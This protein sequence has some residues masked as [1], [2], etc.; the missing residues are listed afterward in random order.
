MQKSQT[1]T[2][3]NKTIQHMS[4]MTQGI[5]SGGILLS[6]DPGLG[7]AQPLTSNIKTPTGWTTMGDI[8]VGDYVSVPDGTSAPVSGVYPQGQKQ[9]YKITFSD[10]RTARACGE[11]LWETF[12]LRKH[13]WEILNTEQ[14]KKLIETTQRQV[15]IPLIAQSYTSDLEE[16]PMDPYVLGCLLGDG[17]MTSSS[18]TFS[19][20]DLEMIDLLSERL[21]NGY[22]LFKE[23]SSTCDYRLIIDKDNNGVT[24]PSR[25]RGEFYNSYRERLNDLGLLGSNSYT[26]F[27]PQLYK[28][29]S[30]Q[31]KEDLIAG[32]VDTDGHVT[33]KGGSVSISTSSHTMALDIQEIVWSMGGVCIIKERHPTYT[34]NGERKNG[35]VSYA[36]SIRYPTPRNL[37]KLTRKR[38]LLP[39]DT[40]QYKN[41]NLRIVK[42]EEDGI[43]EAQCIMVDHPDHL[44]ITDN[45]VVTHNTT[46]CELLGALLGIK[47]IIIEVPHITEE[48][49]INIPFLVY[50][51]VTNATQSGV[52]QES[53]YKM[54]LAQSNLYTQILNARPM[55]DAAYIQ[56]IK[57]SSKYIQDLYAQFGGTETEIPEII[58][59]AR[60]NFTVI[61]FLDEFFRRAP[62][63]VRNV[64]RD[65]LNKRIGMHKIPATTYILYASNMNDTGLDEMPSNYQFTQVDYK[66]PN[67]KDWFGW[68]ESKYHGSKEVQ[69]NEEV[70]AHFQEILTDEDISF[71]DVDSDVRTSPRRWEQLLLYIN[72]SLPVSD[73]RQA[74]ALLTNIH[75]NFVHYQ[76]KEM[77][78]NL[79]AK[80]LKAV[81]KLIKDTSDITVKHTDKLEESDWRD[82]L[83]HQITAQMKLGGHKKHIP[84]ISG[85][86]GVG[87]S[88]HAWDLAKKHNLR[89]IPV[90]ISSIYADDATGLPIPGKSDANKENMSIQ[91]S[92]PKL[93]HQIMEQIKAEDALYISKLKTEHGKKA[94]QYIDQYE[95]A[96]WKYL[97]MFDEINRVDEKTFNALRKV[98]LEKNFGP[99]GDNTGEDLR[100]PKEAI[101]IAALN[102][103]GVGTADLTSH[104][105]DVV[106]FVHAKASWTATLKVL[107]SLEVKDLRGKAISST[108]KEAGLNIIQMFVGKFKTKSS[109]TP[110]NEQPYHLDIGIPVYVSSREY[111]D[112]M[113]GLVQS[114]HHTIS[115][116]PQDA[117][118]AD[119]R[120]DINDTVAD[121]FDEN[122]SFPLTKAG[123][124]NTEFLSQVR[125]WVSSLPASAFVGLLAKTAKVRTIVDTMGDYLDGKNLDGM[126]DD[127][128]LVNA[129]NASNNSQVI[130]EVRE[131]FTSKVTDS[132]KVKHYIIDQNQ[133][134][135]TVKD[136]SLV[137]AGEP[138]SLLTNFVTSLIYTLHMHNYSNDRLAVIG[139]AVSV[140]FVEILKKMEEDD[141]IDAEVF[142]SARQAIS[143]LR[144]NLIDVVGTFK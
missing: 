39:D 65:I 134:S 67:K 93:Y 124:D 117:K 135:V 113:V 140:S 132:S 17:G 31:Q 15:H 91:F 74:H 75:N 137:Y 25:T 56:H 62:M 61:L 69:L 12:V 128:S 136:D 114:L 118:P 81:A 32:L 133:K 53:D 18:L 50:N 66:A 77:S 30:L 44:Y 105:R 70:I 3:I 90:D 72:A 58:K 38:D 43:E 94:E 22:K 52:S 10:G 28:T 127:V 14:I 82:T 108:F 130:D 112:L 84:I 64:L 129:H 78:K 11:H 95:H 6:G 126:L 48:H 120:R 122:L 2:L 7:K 100:L 4:R 131:M 16:L 96:R 1:V 110:L 68:F 34:Y 138:T 76:T 20:V 88:S 37:S 27:I 103:E 47:T 42:I 87:K 57:K 8:Q 49:L 121:S 13:S 119:V 123:V 144:M 45:Y 63:R 101:I 26:K 97:I 33:K 99:V 79:S 5:Q 21:D 116:L 141:T 107:N 73:E 9:I 104:F 24:K 102:P 142:R 98:I 111:T 109:D 36:V 89:Y 83:D 125:A 86:P 41:L 92:L 51:P 139:K 35:A 71:N 19:T 46:F 23:R 54:V 55:D 115:S 40:Y 80:V 143:E 85:P 60:S 59:F 106:D 29:A